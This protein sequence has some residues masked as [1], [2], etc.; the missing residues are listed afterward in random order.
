MFEEILLFRCQITWYGAELRESPNWPQAS[1][2]PQSSARDHNQDG[3]SSVGSRFGVLLS[4]SAIVSLAVN[5][6]YN[7]LQLFPEVVVSEIDLLY[8]AAVDEMPPREKIARAMGMFNWS[9]EFIGREVRST[10]P[11]A[12]PDKLKLLVALRI[13]GSDHK[14]RKLIEGLLANVPD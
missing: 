12:S 11:D 5:R 4:K 3:K 8:Q 7:W 9:R 14:A 1:D 10:N 6:R 2:Q 13:Y